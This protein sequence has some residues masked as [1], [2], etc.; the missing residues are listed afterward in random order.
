[1]EASEAIRRLK[2]DLGFDCYA[3]DLRVGAGSQ[4]LLDAPL[5][6][7]QRSSILE[8][9]A[10]IN[11]AANGDIPSA[12]IGLRNNPQVIVDAQYWVAEVISGGLRE[13][14]KLQACAPSNDQ[15]QSTLLAAL[16]AVSHAWGQVLAGDIDN[17]TEGK[18]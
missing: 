8:C 5:I 10:A 13:L 14:I 11:H 16:T 1:M 18:E 15:L 7:V 4:R 2:T 17:L 9:L 3:N 12:N 6:R